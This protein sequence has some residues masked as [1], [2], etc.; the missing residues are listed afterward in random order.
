VSTRQPSTSDNTISFAEEKR[1]RV[2]L[3]DDAPDDRAM[4]EEYLSGRGYE[5]RTAADGEEA[6]DLALRFDF[7]IAVVDI[8][9]PRLDGIGVILILRNYSRTKRMPVVTLS[10]RTGLEIRAEAMAAGATRV[11]EKPCEPEMLES[12]IDGLLA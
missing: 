4:Y 6:V 5:V 11:L 1:R 3:V 10:A 2:L 8:A 12:I 9:M 7:E